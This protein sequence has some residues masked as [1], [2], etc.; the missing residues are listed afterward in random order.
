M[1][2]RVALGG[3]LVR[4]GRFVRSLSIMIMRPDDLI[5]F[6][7]RAY[8]RAQS[9]EGWTEDKL[10]DA[11]LR[12]EEKALLDRVPFRGG[13]LLLLGVGGG[14]EAAPLAAMGFEVTGVDFIPA[15]AERASQNLRRRGFRIPVLV[16]DISRLE[17]PGSHYAVAWLTSGTYSS[18]PTRRRRIEMLRRIHRALEPGGHFLCQ[19]MFDREPEFRAGWELAR[20]AFSWITMGNLSYERGDRLA[21]NAEFARYFATDGEVRSEFLEA[22][23]EVVELTL[24]GEGPRGGAVLRKIT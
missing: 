12:P 20:R 10:V 3:F 17:V 5:E 1:S 24:P 2:V 11:G 14:R 21:G 9:I 13:R 18:I 19:F 15:L 8:S 23:F 7:R 4:A 16:Q 6:N 22:G